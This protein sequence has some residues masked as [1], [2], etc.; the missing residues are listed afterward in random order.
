LIFWR[1]TSYIPHWVTEN[2]IWYTN[3]FTES[4]T[5]YGCAEPMSD[6]ES[7]H[8]YVQIIENTPA[9][10]VIHW[11]Y[12]PVD[13]L[14]NGANLNEKTGWFDWTNQ[15][16]YIYPDGTCIRVQKAWSDE[17]EERVTRRYRFKWSGTM[18]GG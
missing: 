5:D 2:N 4:G 10:V 15:Y 1:G 3:E 7:R 17:P 14:Y 18:S 8:S 11:R 13:V 6:K 9:R 12:G 16:H